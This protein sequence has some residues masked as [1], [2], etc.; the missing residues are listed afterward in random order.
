MA[1]LALAPRGDPEK[2]QFFRPTAKGRMAFSAAL[3]SSCRRLS[4]SPRPA[5]PGN[6]SGVNGRGVNDVFGQSVEA[7][8][9]PAC[10]VDEEAENL[11]EHLG[12]GS[13]MDSHA[14]STH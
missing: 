5:K 2:S 4:S 6:G 3:L 8:Q 7:G 12:K 14:P 13:L 10:A 1:A 11:L 9:M